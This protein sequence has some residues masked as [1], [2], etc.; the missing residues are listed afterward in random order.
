MTARRRTWLERA[1]SDEPKKLALGSVVVAERNSGR[2]PTTYIGTVIRYDPSEIIAGD[3]VYVVRVRGE[4]KEHAEQRYFRSELVLMSR[5]EHTEE[6][7]SLGDEPI[8]MSIEAGDD[9]FDHLSEQHEEG[10]DGFMHVEDELF[11][12][13]RVERGM[14]VVNAA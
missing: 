9:R 1:N 14:I 7:E 10:G 13:S 4:P 12:E 11:A 5:G 6:E 2:E 8:A 3:F